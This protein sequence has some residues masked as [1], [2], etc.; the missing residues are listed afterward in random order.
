[1]ISLKDL[2][3]LFD[4]VAYREDLTQLAEN[5]QLFEFFDNNTEEDVV[6]IYNLYTALKELDIIK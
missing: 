6:R 2:E 4:V 3:K 1:M 5:T